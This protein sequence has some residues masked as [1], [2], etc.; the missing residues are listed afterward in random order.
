MSLRKFL[1]ESAIGLD[2]PCAD[3]RDAVRATGDL[4]VA[5]GVTTE[6]YTD[7]MVEAIEKLGPYIV[8]APGLAI[9]HARPSEAVLRT[10][11]SW[12]RPAEPVS[13][14]H[15]KNDPV[16]LVVGLAATDHEQHQAALVQIATVFADQEK[17]RALDELPDA[18]ALLAFLD[19]DA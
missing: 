3:W 14:G 1:D 6:A 7:Q 16:R 9:A 15:A 18:A 19:E 13:F 4:L 2:V 10:G 17:R 11:L 8:I 5:S 12:L